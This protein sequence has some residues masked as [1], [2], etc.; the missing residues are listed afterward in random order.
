MPFKNI[1]YLYIALT[2][3]VI[4]SDLFANSNSINPIGFADE[5]INDVFELKKIKSIKNGDQIFPYDIISTN[6][7]S[8]TN[9]EFKD[10]SV[11]SIGPE[12]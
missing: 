12:S 8:L 9:I 11:L 3:L 4:S 2:F 5:T 6:T 10:G 1:L 7:E